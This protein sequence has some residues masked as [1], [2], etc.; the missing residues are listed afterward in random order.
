LP[1]RSLFFIRCRKGTT[2]RPLSYSQ[3]ACRSSRTR[4]RVLSSG[5][6]VSFLTKE[7]NPHGRFLQELRQFNERRSPLLFRV[8]SSHERRGCSLR[9]RADS[10]YP[11]SRR[12]HDRWRLPGPGQQLQLGRDRGTRRHRPAQ[13]LRRRRRYVAYVVFWIVMPEEPL[14]L[15]S[16]TTPGST[17][18]PPTGS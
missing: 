13:R 12:A 6:G 5:F 1:P 3:R 17:Y 11:P 16:G 10:S 7:V 14:A 9:N 15:P 8:R 18:V 4:L 2:A